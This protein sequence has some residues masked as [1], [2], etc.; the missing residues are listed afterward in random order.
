MRKRCIAFFILVLIL[1][2]LQFIS[3]KGLGESCSSSADCDPCLKCGSSE[4]ELVNTGYSVTSSGD[5]LG[6]IIVRIYYT[7]RIMNVPGQPPYTGTVSFESP[8][9]YFSSLGLIPPSDPFDVNYVCMDPMSSCN[10]EDGTLGV[11]DGGS[12]SFTVNDPVNYLTNG[13]PQLSAVLIN[14]SIQS[15]TIAFVIS[16]EEKNDESGKCVVDKSKNNQDCDPER[17]KVCNDGVCQAKD[18]NLKCYN[19]LDCLDDKKFFRRSNCYV[20]TV[21]DIEEHYIIEE[22]NYGICVDPGKPEAK[23]VPKN[24]LVT[25]DPLF[26]DPYNSDQRI[27]KCP[28]DKV[29]E[30]GIFTGRAY[31][32]AKNEKSSEDQIYPGKDCKG[33]K[34]SDCGPSGPGCGTDPKS[35]CGAHDPKNIKDFKADSKKENEPAW[36]DGPVVSTVFTERLSI[37]ETI[38]TYF[39]FSDKKT[40]DAVKSLAKS[41]EGMLEQAETAIQEGEVTSLSPFLSIKSMFSNFKK[42]GPSGNSGASPTLKKP[43]TGKVIL[44]SDL[45]AMK[46]AGM[47][48]YRFKFIEKGNAVEAEMGKYRHIWMSQ[49][50]KIKDK[51]FRYDVYIV[52]TH[53]AYIIL[54][55]DMPAYLDDKF[56]LSGKSLMMSQDTDPPVSL[57]LFP[58]FVEN[59][60]E[61]DKPEYKKWVPYKIVL[62]KHVDPDNPTQGLKARIRDLEGEAQYYNIVA[63]VLEFVLY[64]IPFGEATDHLYK[65]EFKQAA[66]TTAKDIIFFGAGLPG[67]TFSKSVSFAQNSLQLGVSMAEVGRG[68]YGIYDDGLGFDDAAI[69]LFQIPI[70]ATSGPK[71]FKYMVGHGKVTRKVPSVPANVIGKDALELVLGI[72]AEVNIHLQAVKKQLTREQYRTFL[73]GYAD[74]SSSM[75]ELDAPARRLKHL[76]G[77]DE[78]PI[79]DSILNAADIEGTYTLFLT[80]RTAGPDPINLNPAS[81]WANGE[82]LNW[83]GLHTSISIGKPIEFNTIDIIQ[84]AA[85][86]DEH[87]RLNRAEKLFKMTAIEA[88]PLDPPPQGGVLPSYRFSEAPEGFKNKIR[89]PSNIQFV[90]DNGQRGRYDEA[91][92]FLKDYYNIV[93]PEL[94][95]DLPR[96][97]DFVEQLYYKHTVGYIEEAAHAVQKSV[98]KDATD[99]MFLSS[100]TDDLMN[101]QINLPAGQKLSLYQL[102]EVD[103]MYYLLEYKQ[104]QVVTPQ[105]I[106]RGQVAEGLPTAREI[107][108]EFYNKNIA[109][110][111]NYAKNHQLPILTDT[112]PYYILSF[113]DDTTL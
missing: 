91:I 9:Y 38:D 7:L 48:V 58:T 16:S 41:L 52:E 26:L 53:N 39:Y 46:S 61:R 37:E 60:R 47:N 11:G 75:T 59:C 21:G 35:I 49:V 17:T 94:I 95:D 24:H 4:P 93:H 90:F 102:L 84:A 68:I 50:Y 97:V 1:I 74:L 104:Y 20:V 13:P 99:Y 55:K 105:F 89:L 85:V 31:C 19:D 92:T 14:P 109:G 107:G 80:G 57:Y 87:K 67:S 62:K 77:T 6:G 111:P 83:P 64:V 72:S 40:K 10:P 76:V 106:K 79:G 32:K 42:G 112:P 5:S 8:D 12:M 30:E 2:N 34:E 96:A 23:C 18:K 78:V 25:K 71:T 15:M 69:I 103:F 54:K 70:I 44:E 110:N 66:Y 86:A 29:C 108:K 100:W 28:A 101:S 45:I 33:Q 51:E 56:G 3:S 113:S 73:K 81:F 88:N 36:Q 65:G 82:T 98:G 63:G 22:G 43:L 27:T